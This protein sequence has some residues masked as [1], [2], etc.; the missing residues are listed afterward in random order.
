V[1]NALSIDLEDWFHAELVRPHVKHDP[2][3]RRVE[4]AVEPILALLDRHAVKATFFVVGDVLR[5]H[6]ELIVR[7][8]AAGHEIGCH[9][10]THRMIH[11]LVPE[12]FAWEIDTFD[13]E[14]AKIL[15][16][17]EIVGFRA[18][19]FSVDQE[20]A[21]A[22]DILRQRGY[23]Y[24]SSVF[25]IRTFL[26]GVDGCPTRPY[27]PTSSELTIDHADGAFLEF[28]MSA[29][30]VAGLN[31]PVSGGF[32]LRATPIALL[33]ELLARVNRRGDPFVIYAHPWETDGE[34][35]RV[36]GL[37]PISRFITYHNLGG[38]LKKLE[39]LLTRFEFGPLRRVLGIEGSHRAGAAG[40][41][42]MP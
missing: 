7:I 23:L 21:W 11:S 33:R 28:P 12:R 24:D 27:R 22:L 37:S 1:L 39:T 13:R 9:G 20:S 2:P 10:W 26:Y 32:Y 40:L 8:H 15:P 14:A 16:V 4:W 30:R 36:R 29:L 25:P 42:A 3:A 6:P 41:T 5:H 19:S 34:T 38:T 31:I 18:P 17:E 35:P